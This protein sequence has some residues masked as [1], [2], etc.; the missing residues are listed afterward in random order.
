L[1]I[2]REPSNSFIVLRHVTFVNQQ[3]LKLISQL[4]LLKM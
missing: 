1:S 4:N 3:L 2:R